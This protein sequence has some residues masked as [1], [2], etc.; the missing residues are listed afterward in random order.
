LEKTYGQVVLYT[1]KTKVEYKSKMPVLKIKALV[2]PGNTR[3]GAYCIKAWMAEKRD[4]SNITKC[5]PELAYFDAAITTGLPLK[6]AAK[7]DGD[8]MIAFGHKTEKKIKDIFIE[9]KIPQAQRANWPLVRKGTTVVW[10]CGIR[11]SDV[12]PVTVKTKKVL[13]LEFIRK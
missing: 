4:V 8:R 10:L 13:C 2:M 7:G 9:T 5:P 6:I 3:A 12:F 1:L 11:R